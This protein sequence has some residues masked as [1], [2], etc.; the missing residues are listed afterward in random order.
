MNI[1]TF[2]R[3]QMSEPDGTP[4]NNRIMLFLLLT[5]TISLIIGVA[6]SPNLKIVITLPVIPDSFANF[7]E[8]MAG[9]L[10]GGTAVGKAATAYSTSKGG[11]NAI[12]DGPK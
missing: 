4:S 11:N 1:S 6:V 10:V 3:L 9:I 8:W 2:L 7:I 12:S 5:T